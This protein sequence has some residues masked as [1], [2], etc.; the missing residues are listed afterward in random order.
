MLINQ[1]FQAALGN[2]IID[3]LQSGNYSEFK[4]IVAYAKTS[5]VNRLLPSMT[6]FKAMGGTILGV[7]GIDQFNTSYEA[8]ISLYN[9]CNELYIYH[10][11]DPMKTF[12]VKAYSLDGGNTHWNAIGSNNF[13]AGGL[14]SNYEACTISTENN[15]FVSTLFVSY[16]DISSPCCKKLTPDLIDL[17]LENNYIQ[18]EKTLARQKVAEAKRQ[19]SRPRTD[20][21]FGRDPLQINSPKPSIPTVTKEPDKV[22]TIISND[23]DY[24][25]RFVPRAGD[26]SQQVHFTMDILENFFSKAAGDHLRIQQIVDIYNPKP[27]E[28]RQIVFSQKN[29]NVRIEVKA[30]EDLNHNYPAD[31]SKRPI[32]IFKKVSTDFFEYMLINE[33]DS[34][35]TELNY[36]LYSLDWHKRSLQYEIVDTSTLLSIWEDCPLI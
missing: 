35:Y 24:L 7:V 28:E 17:L 26:R 34:G 30:A 3:Q 29:R 1:P 5:G 6:D 11:E 18:K 23:K 19:R 8:L 13:T 10:S 15:A 36:R 2:T 32:L 12:H 31:E 4:F 9:V 22:S 33:G 25:I 16:S 21:I 14:F 20:I 27:I